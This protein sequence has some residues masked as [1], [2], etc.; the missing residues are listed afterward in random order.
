MIC[1]EKLVKLYF[2]LK[3][4]TDIAYTIHDGYVVYANKENWKNIFKMG[5]DVLSEDSEFCP[6]L[7]LKVSVKAGRNL[8][9]LK[10]ISR[11]GD[12]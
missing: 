12:L 9:D 1:L 10:T 4:K 11:K 7:K 3:N 6:G 2:K 8:N 5:H